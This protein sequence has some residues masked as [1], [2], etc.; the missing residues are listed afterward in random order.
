V[1]DSGLRT[2]CA[3]AGCGPAG[4]ILGLL[5]ARA[6]LDVVVLEKHADFLR[7]WRGDTIHSSTLEILDEL[8]LLERFLRLPHHKATAIRIYTDTG[9]LGPDVF[10]IGLKHPY[11]A[12]MPQWDFLELITSEAARYPNFRLLMRAEVTGLL[13]EDG[14][15][16]GVRFRGEDGAGHDL[17]AS[18]T[19][20]ADG[21]NSALRAAAGFA[22]VAFSAPMDV[23]AM[24]VSRASSDPED[25]FLRI[26]RGSVVF[27][28]NRTAYWQMGY[29]IP[30]GGYEELR[31]AGIGAAR[32]VISELL[33]FL[34]DRI[35]REIRTF[36]D[37]SV[38]EVRVDRLRR[39]HAPGLLFIGDAAHAM[40]PIAGVGINLAVQDAVATANLLAEPLRAAIA[41]G[42]PLDGKALAAV[43]RRRMRPT[44][45][46]QLLQ[47]LIQASVIKPAMHND[48]RVVKG[49]L[50][51]RMAR[52]L[53]PLRRR[54]SRT[55]AIGVR[56]EHVRSAA[57]ATPQDTAPLRREN[58]G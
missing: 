17:H 54:M 37:I 51:L 7:D 22:P 9:E 49:P 1:T 28:I 33:P 47:R 41:D 10:D 18:L 3:I 43:Q 4:A 11:I 31:N 15:V 27:L 42:R 13:R 44:V 5:L 55:I 21:R 2:G 38:L 57:R 35:E 58:S 25:P 50:G 12:W 20:A 16:T 39:W 24:R 6:G 30:K 46:T 45:V 52:Y 19:V 32:R 23:V 26:G 53:P 48:H 29:V 14:R 34:T 36:D 40:S 56:P 8:G